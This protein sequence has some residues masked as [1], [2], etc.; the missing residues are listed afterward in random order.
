MKFQFYNEV[1]VFPFVINQKDDQKVWH[2]KLKMEKAE[3]VE[4]AV[5]PLSFSC[6]DIDQK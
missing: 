5:K 4:L 6:H 3:Y 1:T 2:I